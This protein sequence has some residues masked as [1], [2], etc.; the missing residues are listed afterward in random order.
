[1]DFNVPKAKRQSPILILILY[2]SLIVV[3]F[4]F[5]G[6]FSLVSTDNNVITSFYVA[7]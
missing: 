4:Y 6:N 2:H 3:I 1:M 5:Q 7:T